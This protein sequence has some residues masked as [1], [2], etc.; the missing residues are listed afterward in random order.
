MRETV[1]INIKNWEEVKP[2]VLEVGD[3]VQV[4]VLGLT[5]FIKKYCVVDS[6]YP[7]LVVRDVEGGMYSDLSVRQGSILRAPKSPMVL[8]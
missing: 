6:V 2:D 8:E 7:E 4:D 5:G 1:P 3:R